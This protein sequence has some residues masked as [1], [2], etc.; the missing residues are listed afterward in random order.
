MEEEEIVKGAQ[1]IGAILRVLGFGVAVALVA[2]AV[3]LWRRLI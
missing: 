1:A 2:A 3:W